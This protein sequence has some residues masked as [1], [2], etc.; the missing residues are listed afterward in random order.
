MPGFTLIELMFMLGLAATVGAAT[1]PQVLASL[2]DFR[3]AGAARTI[4]AQLQQ[5]RGRAVAR[6][7][8]TAVRVTLD[9]R[10]Y[11]LVP[12]EDGNANGVRAAD[13]QNGVD[14]AIGPAMRLAADFPGVE[15]GAIAGVPGADGSAAPG[16]DPIRLGSADSVTFTPAGTATPGSLYLRGGRSAQYAVRIYGETGRT[17]I[18]RYV[19]AKRT[20]VPL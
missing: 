4:T 20:W 15:F 16:A 18:L 5:A 9:A 3:A 13:I 2:D 17:R 19:T 10:G 6:G 14:R 12:F 7:R 8:D 11:V 1:V